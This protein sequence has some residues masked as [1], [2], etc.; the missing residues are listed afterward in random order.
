MLD[1]SDEEAYEDVACNGMEMTV[2]GRLHE[3]S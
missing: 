1:T 3:N 2:G